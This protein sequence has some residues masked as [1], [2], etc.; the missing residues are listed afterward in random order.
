MANT[1]KIGAILIR[2]GFCREVGDIET[3]A[4]LFAGSARIA[5]IVTAHPLIC[6]LFSFSLIGTFLF[7]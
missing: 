6:A 2:E 4:S 1:I 3:S 5:F 7:N